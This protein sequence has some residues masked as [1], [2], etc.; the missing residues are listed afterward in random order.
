MGNITAKELKRNTGEILRR[1]RVG[2]RFTITH[3]GKPVAVLAPLGDGKT[4]APEGLHPFDEAWE[5]IEATL[6]KS[7]PAF[8]HWR[9]ALAWTRNRRLS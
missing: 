5:E 3:R 2:G 1:V 8:R 6:Q 4:D 7:K 9:E